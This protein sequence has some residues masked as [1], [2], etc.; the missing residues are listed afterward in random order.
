MTWNVDVYYGYRS[1]DDM[2][3]VFVA[4]YVIVLAAMTFFSLRK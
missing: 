2:T 1:N 3:A 4:V